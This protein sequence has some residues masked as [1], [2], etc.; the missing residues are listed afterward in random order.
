MTTSPITTAPA[1]APSCHGD[2]GQISPASNGH[3]LPSTSHAHHHRPADPA[4][5]TEDIDGLRLENRNLRAQLASLPVIEQTKGILMDR[6]QISSDAAFTVLQRWSS[7]TNLKLRDIS[8]LLVEAASHRDGQAPGRDQPGRDLEQL[9]DWLET[10][11]K[12]E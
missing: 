1:P 12:T 6:Y 8:G 9:I 7:H 10:G 5:G 2:S 4:D 3:L 11:G